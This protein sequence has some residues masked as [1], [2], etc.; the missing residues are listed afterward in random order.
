MDQKTYTVTLTDE[1]LR[2]VGKATEVYARVSIGQW[3]EA[4]EL[5]PLEDGLD[6]DEWHFFLDDLG[7]RLSTFLV[8][9]VDGW[10]SS[11]G[12]HNEKVRED[13]RVAFD[14]HSAVRHRED[15]DYGTEKAICGEI[16]REPKS[17]PFRAS[18]TPYPAISRNL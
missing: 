3:R 4:F 15:W 7:A 10:R 12:I 11:L 17:S 6:Y 18:S 1:Q 13:A 8:S 5:L 9:G 14:I 2:V 16:P